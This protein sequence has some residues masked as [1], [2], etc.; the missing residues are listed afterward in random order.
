M[1]GYITKETW[2]LSGWNQDRFDVILS[3]QI[4]FLRLN[5]QN[6]PKYLDIIIFKNKRFRN[7]SCPTLSGNFCPRVTTVHESLMQIV[8][9]VKL[10]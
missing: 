2:T 5:E 4:L 6:I 8:Q 9:N 7:S 3:L 1:E 10:G